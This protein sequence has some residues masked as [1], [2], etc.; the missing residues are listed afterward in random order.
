MDT[1]IE[2]IVENEIDRKNDFYQFLYK[3][4]DQT[5]KRSINELI[6]RDAS[7]FLFDSFLILAMLLFY[8]ML[9]QIHFNIYKANKQIT[10]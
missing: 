8:L 1:G 9:W 3:T 10:M 6:K 5:L 7:H 2:T 4:N